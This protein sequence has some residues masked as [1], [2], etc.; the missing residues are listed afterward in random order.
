[1]KPKHLALGVL[2]T[3]IWGFNFVPIHV[4]LE[5]F[6]PLLATGLRFGLAGLLAFVLPKPNLPLKQICLIAFPLFLGQF[7]LMFLGM[8]VGM[9]PGMASIVIQTQPFFTLLI[10]TFWLKE[11]PKPQ[12]IAGIA[13]AMSGLG[14]ISLTI[15]GDITLAGLL[16]I[17]A[18]AANWAVGNVLLRKAGKVKI[19]PLIVWMNAVSA[20]PALLLSLVIDGPSLIAHSFEHLTPLTTGSLLYIVIMST[21]LGYGLWGYLLRHYS[22]STVAPFSLLVPVFGMLSSFLVFG[23]TFQPLRLVG[24]GLI[25]A[26]LAIIVLLKGKKERLPAEG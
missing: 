18:A 26:G 14:L 3:A 20:L 2:I 17:V 15:G 16:C 23:E 12:Q 8:A 9:P 6:P 7:L 4:V 5:H 10:A 24:A 13:I 22:A 19:L 11:K 21:M 25:L 1:M